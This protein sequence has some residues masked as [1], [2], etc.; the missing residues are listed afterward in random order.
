MT[1]FIILNC[2]FGIRPFLTAKLTPDSLLSL[3]VFL[4]HLWCCLF[5]LNLTSLSVGI[6][7]LHLLQLL[8]YYG[9]PPFVLLLLASILLGWGYTFAGP[10]YP[11]RRPACMDIFLCW[12]MC[13]AEEASKVFRIF[14]C[15]L[16]TCA[17]PSSQMVLSWRG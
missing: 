13:F 11:G 9:V 5:S 16:V 14:K 7:T 12:R 15:L 2:I 3:E 10:F 1:W 6:L 8:R 4:S 17:P